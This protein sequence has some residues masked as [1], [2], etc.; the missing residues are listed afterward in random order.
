MSDYEIYLYPEY[1]KV[2]IDFPTDITAT[3]NFDTDL[4]SIDA[5]L[6]SDHNGDTVKMTQKNSSEWQAKVYFE[7]I[8]TYKIRA[9]AKA[10]DGTIIEGTVKIEVVAAGGA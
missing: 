2:V 10:P 3:L 9:T 6:N 4:V 8:G 7:K 1:R 5:Y